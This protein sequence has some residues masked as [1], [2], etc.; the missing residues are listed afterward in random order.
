MNVLGAT[1]YPLKQNHFKLKEFKGPEDE[2]KKGKLSRTSITKSVGKVTS[3]GFRKIVYRGNETHSGF[4]KPTDKM[5]QTAN[6][7]SQRKEETKKVYRSRQSPKR[8]NKLFSAKESERL[9]KSYQISER[10][11]LK[12]KVESDFMIIK[13]MDSA[14]PV[15]R[16]LEFV[17]DFKQ[18]VKGSMLSSKVPSRVKQ[19]PVIVMNSENLTSK[20]TSL[21]KSSRPAILQKPL[22][23]SSPLK[24]QPSTTSFREIPELEGNT[25]QASS[26]QEHQTPRAKPVEPVVTVAPAIKVESKIKI[27]RRQAKAQS[28]VEPKPTQEPQEPGLR[29]N[30]KAEL[31]RTPRSPNKSHVHSRKESLKITVLPSSSHSKQQTP[32]N[33]DILD[34]H[35]Y[36][37]FRKRMKEETRSKLDTESM[38]KDVRISWKDDDEHSSLN[39]N[40]EKHIKLGFKIGEGSFGEVYEGWDKVLEQHVGIKLFSKDK[41]AGSQR[42]MKMLEKELSVCSALPNHI[43][44]CQFYRVVQDANRVMTGS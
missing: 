6:Y 11:P 32:T 33:P 23:R 9:G 16:P 27:F 35:Y 34:R 41:L 25:L 10:I 21:K 26:H 30:P 8:A 4:S 42:L 37:K 1:M 43:N 36:H 44:I 5:Q 20:E 39:V 28:F 24:A 29:T 2:T 7:G 22:K 19:N 15:K 14:G 38:K 12:E 31:E 18:S 3:M 17:Y 13:K 40:M